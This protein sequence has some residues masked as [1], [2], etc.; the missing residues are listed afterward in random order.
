MYPSASFLGLPPS[1]KPNK[2]DLL[3][4]YL[5]TIHDFQMKDDEV[6]SIS[7]KLTTL[8]SILTFI[9]AAISQTFSVLSASA[10][11]KNDA[12]FWFTIK[13]LNGNNLDFQL[14]YVCEVWM[15]SID[16][17]GGVG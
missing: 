4:N 9:T 3:R 5:I 13:C 15:R 10:C 17:P 8:L 6:E 1:V 14:V 7:P 12:R 11:N 16:Q 2:I